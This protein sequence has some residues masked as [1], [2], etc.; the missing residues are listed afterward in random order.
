MY[1][2]VVTIEN[3]GK[4]P[5]LIRINRNFE[6]EWQAKTELANIGT[7]GLIHTTPDNIKMYYPPHRIIEIEV[8][9]T[10]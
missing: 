2:F 4:L 1:E 8:E 10:K 9:E 3:K 7:N 6:N 5:S